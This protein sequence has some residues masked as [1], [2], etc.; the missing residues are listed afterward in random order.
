MVIIA[1]KKITAFLS[2]DLKPFN[3]KRSLGWQFSRLQI[4]SSLKN[5]TA[6]T[7]PRFNLDGLAMVMP[8]SADSSA[9]YTL[10]SNMIS[11]CLTSIASDV[12]AP[13]F[14][15]VEKSWAIGLVLRV[16][17]GL[18]SIQMAPRVRRTFVLQSDQSPKKSKSLSRRAFWGSSERSS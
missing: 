1:L 7:W 10:R 16:A 6:R 8:T 11:A 12:G 5:R 18:Q 15:G 4:A 2:Q 13:L 9:S 14:I 3:V 17:H